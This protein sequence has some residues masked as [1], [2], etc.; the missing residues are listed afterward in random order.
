MSGTL[1]EKAV[2]GFGGSKIRECGGGGFHGRKETKMAEVVTTG[3]DNDFLSGTWGVHGRFPSGP[4]WRHLRFVL[5][6]E[7]QIN[8]LPQCK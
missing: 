2:K 8:L 3:E 4:A 7:G 5:F 1:G 6:A